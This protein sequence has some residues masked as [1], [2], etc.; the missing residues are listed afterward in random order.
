MWRGFHASLST[1]ATVGVAR[2]MLHDQHPVVAGKA[3]GRSYWLAG[4][5]LS[6][7]KGMAW[8]NGMQVTGHSGHGRL[9]PLGIRLPD[10]P[11]DS[12][13]VIE[14]TSLISPHLLYKFIFL[15]SQSDRVLAE[16]I[17]LNLL[18]APTA[19]TPEWPTIRNLEPP[20][21]CQSQIARQ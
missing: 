12:Q 4:M 10:R 2:Q 11:S 1:F 13:T 6:S 16:S 15:S 5:A 20:R 19:T 7:G 3:C 17:P 18:A 21:H 8:P 14:D 9:I